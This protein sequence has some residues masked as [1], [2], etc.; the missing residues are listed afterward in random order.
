MQTY[1]EVGI[2]RYYNSYCRNEDVAEAL[3]MAA[4]SADEHQAFINLKMEMANYVSRARLIE[5]TAS[6]E[7]RTELIVALVRDI[8]A[9]GRLLGLVANE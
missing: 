7:R 5:L 6:Q 8:I 2:S 3:R 1:Q 9:N 4:E